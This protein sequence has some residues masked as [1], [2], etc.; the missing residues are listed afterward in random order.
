M[1][2]P[3]FEFHEPDTFDELFTLAARYGDEARYLAGGTALVLLMHAQLLEPGALLA[4]HRLPGLRPI[5]R[6]DGRLRLGSL[7]THAE[8]A[9]SA[10]L[11][12]HAP[13]LAKAFGHVATPRIR[14]V[15]T[16]GGNLAH[17]DPHQD[18]PVALMA[19]G[20]SVVARGPGGE[21]CIPVDRFFTGF[22]ETALQ[23]GE[24]ITAV[25]VPVA[26]ANVGTAFIK[27]LSRSAD[28]Y[29][30]VN[31]GV[32]LREAGGKVAEARIAVGCMGPTP[33]RLPEAEALLVGHAPDDRRFGLAGEAAAAA[34]S[35]MLD[36]RGS[37]AYKRRIM[38]VVV[39]R[40]A[41][42]AWNSRNTS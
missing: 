6:D 36:S 31:V 25:E 17:A 24:L 21:R 37:P 32:A 39:A 4:L 8:L 16:V 9:Q 19:L 10:L 5:A 15:G 40:A 38:P 30:T 33:L 22:Y 11:R 13:A 28:D 20:A 41:R 34:T 12:E 14:N 26:G 7:A 3:R 2:L 29:A 23:P 18:P 27:F 35:P 42:Q 1:S